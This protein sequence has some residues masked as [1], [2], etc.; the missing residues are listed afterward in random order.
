MDSIFRLKNSVLYKALLEKDTDEKLSSIVIKTVEYVS[1]L[2]HKIPEH[3]PEF[4]LH[5]PSHSAKVVEI[6]AKIIPT[7]VIAQLN[8]IE[9][10]LLILSAY[11]HD[12]GMTCER[13]EKEN[14]IDKDEDFN[15]L[16]KSNIDKFQKFEQYKLEGNHRAAT[17]IQDQIF[18][19][20][21]RRNHVQ[22]S[23]AFILSN[24]QFGQY[25]L[26]Y[27]GIPFHKLLI[28]IC[29]GHGESVQKLKD[30]IIWPRETLIGENIVNIQF[31]SLIL[32]LAD[33]LDLD[34][35][36]TP[37]V[38]YEFVNPENPT[39][40]LEWKK[41]RSIIG[42]SITDKKILFEAECSSPEVERA[43]RQFMDWI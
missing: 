25:S 34:A 40:I 35:E 2:L 41:H 33:I 37:K 15:I 4:T 43:L 24:L 16:F 11:L 1:P 29:D 28:K 31:L 9:V 5:D 13:S 26:I 38:I 42:T 30:N 6:M 20:Y 39:S 12:I 18:T 22:R 21:L 19:E 36:R 14:I 10:A 3:M 7:K 27:Q 32:R 17:F 8:S 23:A